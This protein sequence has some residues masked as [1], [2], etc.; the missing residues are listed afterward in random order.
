MLDAVQILWAPRGVAM[1]SLDKK[2]LIDIHDGDTPSIR[3]PVRMLSIDTPEVTAGSPEGA[4]R[5]DEKFAELA[6]WITQRPSDV[7]I[8]PRFAQ[9][10]LPRLATRNAGT[11]QFTQGTAAADFAKSNAAQRLALPN[12]QQRTVFVSTADSPFDPNGRLLAYL[13]P[14]YSKIEAATMTR[15]QRSTFNLDMVRS[16]WAAP[17]II[18]PSIPGELDL[19]MFLAAADDAV[20]AK[21][22]I[23][24]EPL[25]MPAY[26]YRSVERL[27]AT[28]KSIIV[29]KKPVLDLF[30]WR[31]RYCA[32]MRSRVLVG[33][34]DYFDIDPIYRL[35]IRPDDV[36]DATMRLNLTPSP[37]LVGIE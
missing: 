8:S 33:P 6:E 19:P 22:G 14:N 23:W 2:S 30:A 3:M 31:E 35:W 18:Y 11:L 29:D 28:A 34:E 26:E 5:V 24:A 13:A 17:F 1:T 4:R 15:E 36:R 10:L 37:R 16:G 12:G 32:D 9:Y 20:T 7:P 25:T 21:R 27:H